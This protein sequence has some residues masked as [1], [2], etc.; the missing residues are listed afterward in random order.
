MKPDFEITGINRLEEFIKTYTLLEIKLM[1]EC[2]DDNNNPL[3]NWMAHFQ[4]NNE[5]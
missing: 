5:E 4:Q 3:V 2:N 1:L